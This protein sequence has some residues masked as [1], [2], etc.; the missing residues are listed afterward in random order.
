GAW[1]LVQRVWD[2]VEPAKDA[3]KRHDFSKPP[4]ADDALDLRRTTHRTV[5]DVTD[6]IENFRFNKA[7]ARIYEFLNA[8]KKAPPAKREDGSPANGP[9]AEAYA[10][11]EALSALVRL[12]A[13]FVPHLA[14][15]CWEHLGGPET[16]MGRFVC[17]APWPKADPAL[18]V[19]STLTLGVQVNGKRR[20]EIEV[21][22][23]AD[24][25]TV[26]KAALSD[27]NVTRHIEG[28][29]LRKVVVVPGRV[30]NIVAN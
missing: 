24:S 20:A 25:E 12:V 10:Q 14:E 29:T 17:G 18:L 9:R 4:V 3:L 27:P 2:A 22:A 19:K 13:P 7:I 30:V 21:A 15:E 26:E 8:L 23:D 1:K 16:G 28:L 5:A 11:A 6:D